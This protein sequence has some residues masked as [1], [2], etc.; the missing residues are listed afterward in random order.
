MLL[1]HDQWIQDPGGG[2][3][4][5][6]RRVDAQLGDSTVKYCRRIQ[7]GEG[8][9]RS[10]VCQVIGRD[11]NRLY[12]C[13]GSVL[14]GRDPLLQRT[15]LVGQRRLITYCGRH[16]AQQC[17]H[18]RTR[19]SESEDIVDEQEHV[20]FLFVTEVLRHGQAGQRY[21]H[22]GSWRLVHLSEYH[23]GLGQNAGLGHLTV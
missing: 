5:V 22:S 16:T 7:M 18:L 14:G 19:L 23:G 20:L 4:R 15:H 6:D 17:R 10:R 1:P 13:D 11:V 21:T 9:G 2:C 12:R 3:Q 8:G